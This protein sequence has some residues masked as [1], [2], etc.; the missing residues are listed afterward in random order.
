M[1]YLN[2]LLDDVKDRYNIP[3]DYA[4][5]Q[6]LEVPRATVSRWRQNKNCAEWDVI[7]K[8]ADLL[9]LDDQNV[10]YN[11]IAEKTRNPRLIKALEANR[12]I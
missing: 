2:K 8:L 11:I 1:E 4:L 12:S 6:K 3:S 5:A 9:H 7:F 10:V